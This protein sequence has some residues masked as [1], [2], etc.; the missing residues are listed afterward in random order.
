MISCSLCERPLNPKSGLSRTKQ[1]KI[2]FLVKLSVAF[3]ILSHN[4]LKHILMDMLTIAANSLL[5]LFGFGQLLI[6]KKCISHFLDFC[7]RKNDNLKI[8]K[9]LKFALIV[10]IMVN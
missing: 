4:F 1:P 10:N 2:I 9:L 8:F 7:V 5:V 3:Q 6:S